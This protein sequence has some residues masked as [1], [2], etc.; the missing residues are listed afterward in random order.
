MIPC[1]QRHPFG[2]V[3]GREGFAGAKKTDGLNHRPHSFFCQ[4]G[5]LHREFQ[6]FSIV[7]LL[8]LFEEKGII[9]RSHSSRVDFTNNR[10]FQR[11]KE[12]GFFNAVGPGRSNRGSEQENEKDNR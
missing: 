3:Q 7:I 11:G 4:Y 8:R 12:F 5:S 9:F 6:E 2:W 10:I 1:S